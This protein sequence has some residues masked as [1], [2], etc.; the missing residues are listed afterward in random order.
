MEQWAEPQPTVMVRR[1]GETVVVTLNCPPDNALD[2]V[3]LAALTRVVRQLAEAPPAGG[4]V[5]TGM[6]RSFCGGLSGPCVEA[7][8]PEGRQDLARSFRTL[9]EALQGLE[10]PVVA[11]VNG[12]TFGC[13]LILALTA[14]VR[15]FADTPEGQFGLVDAAGEVLFPDLAL[16][17]V[18]RELGPVAVRRLSLSH[19]PFPFAEALA[20]GLAESCVDP[21]SLLS[22]AVARARS[23][24]AQPGFLALKSLLKS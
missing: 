20:L 15:L 18:G 6:G 17:L 3:A 10:T 11:A 7:L 12:N 21:E 13:G 1:E 16:E 9:I 4:L 19:I 8:S 23:L 5:L 14:D 2:R 24:S 22:T